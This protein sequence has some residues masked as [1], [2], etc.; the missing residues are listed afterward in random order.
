[1]GPHNS[2]LGSNAERARSRNRQ[3]VL[4][5]IRARGAMGR[6]E[7]ARELALSTQAVSN[8]IADL[9]EDGFLVE[10]GARTAGRGL[11]AM[12][13]EINAQGAYALGVEIR[14]SALLIALL[15]LSGAEIGMRRISLDCNQPDH[16][17]NRLLELKADLLADT[18]LTDAR[19]TGAGLVMPGPFGETGLSGQSADLP[20]WQSLDIRAFLEDALDLPV[21][22]SNDAN[23]AA[24]AERLGGA[25][26]GLDS[27]AHIYFGE[28]IG[29]GIVQN[30]QLMRGAFGNAGEIGLIPMPVDG[31]FFPLEECLSRRSINAFLGRDL[32]F[33][34][35]NDL[36]AT[37][38]D[39][40][41]PW[42]AQAC[43]VL[44]QAVMLVENLFDP[45]AIFLG[46]AM[47]APGFDRVD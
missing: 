27:Y 30:G 7:L 1:M 28:G 16:V 8:I 21:D 12:Q 31:G 6:A 13:Y 32:D 3:A 44:S 10:A 20:G 45:Q 29:L 4:G 14:P 23:A 40:L 22:V 36:Y 41:Q 26:Q 18:G 37:Q 39:S 2:F 43:Q 11:P 19:L 38:P 25:A 33:D 17:R 24:L 5:R 47:P 34:A 35:L 15:D 9:L 46:G 42:M